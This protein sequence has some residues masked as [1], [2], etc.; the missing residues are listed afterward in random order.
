MF[1]IPLAARI[2]ALF[3][4]LSSS[5][6]FGMPE[7]DVIH[8]KEG[9]K[10]EGR[11][12]RENDQEVVI[13]TSTGEIAIAR[14][15]IRKIDR[16]PWAVDVF[17]KMWSQVDRKD[18]KALLEL[19]DWCLDP[20]RAH[21]LRAQARKVARRIVRLDK[22]NEKARKV[23]GQVKYKNRWVSKRVYRELKEKEKALAAE[24]AAKAE[25]ERK[26]RQEEKARLALIGGIPIAKQ[27]A[28]NAKTDRA[29]EELLRSKFGLDYTVRSSRRISVKGVLDPEQAAI[30]LKLGER[31]CGTLN[32]DLGLPVASS[33]FRNAKYHRLHLF[34]IRKDQ[35]EKVLHY[36]DG[37]YTRYTP[38]FMKFSIRRGGGVASDGDGCVGFQIQGDGN[39]EDVFCHYLGHAYVESLGGNVGHWFTE[40]FALYC[41]IRFH[42]NAVHLCTTRSRYAQNVTEGDKKSAALVVAFRELQKMKRLPPVR[43]LFRKHMNRLDEKDLAKCWGVVKLFMSDPYRPKFL[44]YLKALRYAG[45]KH[46]KALQ[47]V[48][49]L[50]PEQLDDLV[51]KL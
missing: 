2:L 49:N 8:L 45:G 5:S 32:K 35:I 27:V 10:V 15:R 23:L 12:L 38:D 48:Y 13:L 51:Y 17:E 43:A 34:F 31:I 25:A 24:E 37:T 22:D 46:E 4:L 18:E 19:L 9:A 14:E 44:K 21:Q 30:F 28:E 47:T 7:P 40:G 6:L 36:I 26:A 16:C 50:T 29:E 3:L 1:S 11:I 33:P 39:D 41:S 42:G 20:D